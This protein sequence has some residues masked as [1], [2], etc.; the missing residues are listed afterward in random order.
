[1]PT[2]IPD[3]AD[4]EGVERRIPT[5]QSS[6]RGACGSGDEAVHRIA[7]GGQRGELD[8]LLDIERQYRIAAVP[9]KRLEHGYHAGAEPTSLV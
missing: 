9:R 2:S 8:D 6:A 1:M 7:H 5:D 4:V 3:S